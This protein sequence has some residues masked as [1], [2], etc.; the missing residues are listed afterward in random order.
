MN[1]KRT[2]P[3]ALRQRLRS[4]LPPEVQAEAR[5]IVEDVRSRGEAAL[6]EHAERLGDVP[7]GGPL[8]LDRA[9]L[10]SAAA[11][12]APDVLSL[13]ERTADR[14]RAFAL[15]QRASLADLDHP[16]PG[17][18]AGHRFAPVDVAGCY[19]PGGRH[20]LPS[21]A[22][23]TCVAA[24]A[25]GVAHVCA[26]SPRPLDVTLAALAVAGADSVLLAG[27][28]HGV[29]ALAFGMAGLPRCDVVVGPGNV[30]VTAAKQALYGE[31]GI[32]ML[33]GPSEL[34]VLADS[35]A[36]AAVVAADM[37]AQAEHDPLAE[38]WLVTADPGLVGRVEAELDR[39]L[40]D[41]PT[42]ETARQGLQNGGAVVCG[43]PEAARE[44]VDVL[45]P[46]HLEILTADPRSD[47]AAIRHFGGVFLGSGSAEVLG[48][49]GAGPNH[50]L[51][52]GG[53]ARFSA[54]LSVLHFL[55]CQT[56]LEM[57][58]PEALADDAA[59]LARLEGLEA[60]A[61]AAELRR[62]RSTP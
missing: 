60:H 53:T 31:V 21:S 24:R 62:R 39:Q 5:A 37:L 44:C 55:R 34:A 14:V 56:W 20:P 4:P 59:R 29:A 3:E 7:P 40:E 48:D 10:E 19:V 12:V 6:R 57:D 16:V 43:S 38:A 23:M 22:L 50:T 58:D 52:T 17:G 13:L 54:G 46:E 18:R 41:L 49:Y 42:A 27:G 51:P 9:G 2:T 35:S 47:L 32:D 61:R 15:A 33:A 11:R 30:W 25:A 26:A 8:T 45:A 28:A 36:D 1:L